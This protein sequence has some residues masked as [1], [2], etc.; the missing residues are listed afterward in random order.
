VLIEAELLQQSVVEENVDVAEIRLRLFLDFHSVSDKDLRHILIDESEATIFSPCFPRTINV[1]E[2][3]TFA[4]IRRLLGAVLW[5]NISGSSPCTGRS[6]IIFVPLDG[7][8]R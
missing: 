7:A 6:P 3:N 1:H 8:N 2:C 4:Q 5:K